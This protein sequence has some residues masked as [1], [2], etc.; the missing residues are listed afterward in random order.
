[1][2]K[3]AYFLLLAF[4]VLAYMPLKANNYVDSLIN[5]LTH[6]HSKLATGQINYRIAYAL[7][8]QNPNAARGYALNALNAFKAL[9]DDKRCGR[10]HY[11]LSLIVNNI[12]N[13]EA[14][15]T[16]LLYA[17]AYSKA[18]ADTADLANAYVSLAIKALEFEDIAAAE[19]HIHSAEKLANKLLNKD[20]SSLYVQKGKVYYE[21]ELYDQALA[22]FQKAIE[23]NP[24]R[25][26]SAYHKLKTHIELQQYDEAQ[27]ILNTYAQH[28]DPILKTRLGIEAAKMYQYQHQ[29][30]QALQALEG[31][32]QEGL[33]DADLLAAALFRKVS[34]HQALGQFQQAH[35]HSQQL[36]QVCQDFGLYNHLLHFSPTMAQV[37]QQA[38]Q[39]TQAIALLN[40]LATLQDTLQ[41]P[42]QLQLVAGRQA[43]AQAQRQFDQALYA[44]TFQTQ[45]HKLDFKN[46]LYLSLAILLALLIAS[47]IGTLAYLYKKHRRFYRV[48]VVPYR[49][50]PRNFNNR[51]QVMYREIMGEAFDDPEYGPYWKDYDK[52]YDDG[53]P[54]FNDSYDQ[55]IDNSW[56]S[57]D[58]QGSPITTRLVDMDLVPPEPKTPKVPVAPKAPEN[59]PETPNDNP[60][61]TG[62]TTPT[63]TTKDEAAVNPYDAGH[64]SP[65]TMRTMD[66]DT[67]YYDGMPYPVAPLPPGNEEL[68]DEDP[69]KMFRAPWGGLRSKR[70]M[71]EIE[72]GP[73]DLTD[74]NSPYERNQDFSQFDNVIYPPNYVSPYEEEQK[75]LLKNNDDGS[76]DQGQEGEDNKGQAP[77]TPAQD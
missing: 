38:G 56:L 34:V 29:Y 48:A 4:C 30:V 69:K 23:F 35:A 37:A 68:D 76:D 9:N 31:L 25:I 57:P 72:E 20:L 3:Y 74:P 65:I 17:A 1:M 19:K 63:A 22:A 26:N 14:T 16:N 52:P 77:S 51:V 33:K 44:S 59:S 42:Q 45:L 10:T 66:V 24:E 70:V 75:D 7:Q 54:A 64:Y 60:T 53:S 62:T 11:L 55:P 43:L 73:I 13:T 39:P 12:G 8:T 71:D 15:Y 32:P 58:G 40:N 2:R 21:Q 47:G 5:E 41:L 27:A 46:A 61:N 18:A 6:K 36:Q 67:V 50:D 28:Q 49:K